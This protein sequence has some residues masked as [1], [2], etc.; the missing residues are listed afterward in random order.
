[1]VYRSKI[2]EPLTALG[3]DPADVGDLVFSHLHPDHPLDA[4]LF[5]RA[6]CHDFW[7][8]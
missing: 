4:T 8:I 5:E 1:M 7:A 3:V 2:L 6:W